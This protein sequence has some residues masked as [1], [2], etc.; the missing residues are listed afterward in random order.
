MTHLLR[1]TV[2]AP[3]L[4]VAGG[5]ALTVRHPSVARLQYK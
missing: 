1:W 2:I 3:M 4:V 5:C